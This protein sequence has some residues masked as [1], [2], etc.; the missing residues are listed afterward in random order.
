MNTSNILNVNNKSLSYQRKQSGDQVSHETSHVTAN[1]ETNVDVKRREL[2]FVE[3]LNPT[4]DS[5]P[6]NV[7]DNTIEPHKYSL[8]ESLFFQLHKETGQLMVVTK[9]PETGKVIK[10]VPPEEFLNT[11]GHIKEAIGNIVDKTG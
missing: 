9:D 5:P 7:A 4:T 3:T 11:L 6:Q 8:Y 2:P 10:T 1:A